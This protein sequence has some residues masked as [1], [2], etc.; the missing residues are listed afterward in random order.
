MAGSSYSNQQ[1]TGGSTSNPVQTPQ[2]QWGLQLSQL[3]SAIGN[4]QYNWAMNQFNNGMG[5][6]DQNINQYMDLAGKGAGLAQN[7]ISR[8]TD[9]FEPLMNQF[10]QQAGT[11]NSEG[12]Q[13]FNMGQAE[14]TVAQADQQARDE[15]ER[16]LQGFGI[17]PNSGRYQDLMLTSRIQDAAARAGAGTQASLNTAA[18]G[19]QMLQ[20]AA[21]M[22][23]NVPG[24]AVNALQSAYTGV[25][26]AENA[27]LGMLNTG[28]NLT[29]SAAPFYNAASGAIKNPSQ[30]QQAANQSTGR[31]QSVTTNPPQN[32][33]DK[34]Q[35]Q[36]RQ[37]SQGNQGNQQGSGNAQTGGP[38]QKVIPNPFFNQQQPNSK[39]TPVDPYGNGTGDNKDQGQYFTPAPYFDPN[40]VITPMGDPNTAHD[41]QGALQTPDTA[42]WN[43]PSG[44]VNSWTLPPD[45]P[46]ASNPQGTSPF[47]V[48][49]NAAGQSA[50]SIGPN[51]PQPANPSDP[52]GGNSFDNS[53]P[54][55]PQSGGLDPNSG[56]AF[57]GNSDWG[58]VA[59]QMGGFS[60]DAS[61]LAGG[62]D[63]QPQGQTPDYSSGNM[64]SY[65]QQAPQDQTQQSPDYSQGD[66][67]S[68]ARGGRVSRGSG[69]IPTTGGHVSRNMSPSGGRKTDDVPARLNADEFVM[70]RD[71]VHHKG[72][73]FFQDIIKKSRMARTG[74]SGAPARAQRKAPLPNMNQP[75]FVSRPMGASQ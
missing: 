28:S 61:Q 42:Q 49:P 70:P 63:Q 62:F 65:Q 46:Q 8:Y 15:A 39:E 55:S 40:G 25:T 32:N 14:S 18:T 54:Y 7:L 41:S 2:S 74:M 21:Q 6:T 53:Q 69:V 24:M 31:S 45:T 22:G 33:Q 44:P 35:G 36:Q 9:T 66:M 72:T 17:N 4:N 13:R 68:Y 75:R 56:E 5:I 60:Q 19:R 20:Q 43:N 64:G 38:G 48:D 10:I 73:G 30:A 51:S 27:I 59:S 58:N 52:W 12:R 71:V 50:Q 37:P 47:N 26:G 1:S 29:Q 57:A 67:G 11:Y 3:L 23:Q 34:S 16:Q